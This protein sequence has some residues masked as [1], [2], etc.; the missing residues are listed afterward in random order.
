MC[1]RE[2]GENMHGEIQRYEADGLYMESRL[3]IEP[4]FH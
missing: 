3:H 1:C 4:S 2:G